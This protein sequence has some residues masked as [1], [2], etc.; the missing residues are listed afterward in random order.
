MTIAKCEHF[1]YTH[2]STYTHTHTNIATTSIVD[3]QFD[4]LIIHALSIIFFSTYKLYKGHMPVDLHSLTI[5]CGS[6]QS[7]N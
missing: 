6:K 7:E 3:D 1:T 5:E 2:S 4:E